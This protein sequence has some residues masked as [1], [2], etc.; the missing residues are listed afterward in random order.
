MIMMRFVRLYALLFS[1]SLRRQVAFRADLAFELVR[2]LIALTASLGA[3]LAVFTRTDQLGGFT[4]TEAVALLG[5]FQLI[6]GLRQALVEPNLRFYGGQVADGRFDAVLTQPAPSIFLAS[7]GGAA[8]I[9]LAQ[10]ALGLVVVVITAGSGPTTP[11]PTA[12]AGWLVLVIA[13]TVIMWAT[14]CLI[15]ASVFWALGFSLDVAYDALWQLGGYPTSMLNPPLRLLTT[16]LPVAFLATA[17]AGV[18][19]GAW[20]PV[21][22]GAGAAVAAV[23][24]VLAVIVWNRG[25]RNYGSATS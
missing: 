7:L 10:A 22:V 1:L 23:S 4:L 20:S 21:W 25:V 15:A 6:S 13:A 5:T 8:P 12:I 3:L 16:I 24:A 14:R 17:P 9:A 2:T 19:V 18:L 11:G